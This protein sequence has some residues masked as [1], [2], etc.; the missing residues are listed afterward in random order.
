MKIKG[1]LLD[2]LV[3]WLLFVI[4]FGGV[5]FILLYSFGVMHLRV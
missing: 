3:F 2:K 4:A 5:L 1:E